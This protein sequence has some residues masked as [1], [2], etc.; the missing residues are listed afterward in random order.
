MLLL[1]GADDSGEGDVMVSDTVE[2]IARC[3]V[4]VPPH[5]LVPG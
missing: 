1:D 5:A 4:S 3:L 2:D